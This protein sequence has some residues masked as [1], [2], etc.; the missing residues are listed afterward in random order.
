MQKYN[1]CITVWQENY[2]FQKGRPL[3]ERALG[4]LVGG[5]SS[6]KQIT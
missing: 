5:L 1:I 6:L 4:T 3:W 2:R